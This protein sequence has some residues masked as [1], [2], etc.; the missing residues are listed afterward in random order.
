MREVLFAEMAFSALHL[1]I[2]GTDVWSDCLVVDSNETLVL[3]E[4][5]LFS[6]NCWRVLLPHPE[7]LTSSLFPS[8]NDAA[9]L[10]VF[11]TGG[12]S[13]VRVH[14]KP[15][16]EDAGEENQG[17]RRASP[18][19]ERLRSRSGNVHWAHHG[20]P[21]AGT[22]GSRARKFAL[23]RMWFS[24]PGALDYGCFHHKDYWLWNKGCDCFS[25][26]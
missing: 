25:C 3:K 17:D 21:A 12:P 14:R 9:L 7:L 16:A 19:R 1:F 24:K 4:C 26:S 22:G 5:V 23:P 10:P 2:I 18:D 6:L 15:R 20:A 13:W 11:I 8:R